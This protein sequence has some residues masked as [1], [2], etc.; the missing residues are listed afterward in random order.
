MAEHTYLYAFAWAT[1]PDLKIGPGVDARFEVEL[2]RHG[3]LAAVASRVG[4][5]R[6]GQER[7]EAKTVKDVQ[8]LRCLAL[9]HRQIIGE[10]VAHGPVMPLPLGVLF[11]DR[12]SLLWRM[13]RC[14]VKVAEFLHDLD[15]QE[16]RVTVFAHAGIRATLPPYHFGPAVEMSG[17]PLENLA[18]ADKMQRDCKDGTSE[19]RLQQ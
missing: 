2:I 6:F 5:D 1:C 11:H 12:P 3:Q 13:S 18:D 19:I 10:V 17:P 15:R 4:F 8:W 7:F 14:E 16:R 9:R